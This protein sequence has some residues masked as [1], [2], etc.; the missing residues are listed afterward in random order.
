LISLHTGSGM[1]YIDFCF[2]LAI[3][4]HLIFKGYNW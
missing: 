2:L 4:S 1:R 3:Y